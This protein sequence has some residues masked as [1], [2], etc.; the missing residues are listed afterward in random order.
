M[1]HNLG[2]AT[3][4]SRMAH[5]LR[6]LRTPGSGVARPSREPSIRMRLDDAHAIHL[7]LRSRLKEVELDRRG[8]V[9]VA[10]S[11]EPLA[12]QLHGALSARRAAHGRGREVVVADDAVR[13]L[14]ACIYAV[15]PHRPWRS[16]TYLHDSIWTALQRTEYALTTLRWAALRDTQQLS[17]MEDRAA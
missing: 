3:G 5:L 4:E 16:A 17:D 13:L 14:W 2:H 7:R 11:L 6:S 15:Q 10:R 1:D 8:L 12:V 9:E